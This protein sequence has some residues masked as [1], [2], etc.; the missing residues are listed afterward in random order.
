MSA[1]LEEKCGSVLMI[2]A[3]RVT[4]LRD[5]T[6]AGTVLPL[7]MHIVLVEIWRKPV[8]MQRSY[9]SAPFGAS[10]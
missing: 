6:P 1:I 3:T 4:W 2:F 8:L 7:D 10:S 5:K 9:M